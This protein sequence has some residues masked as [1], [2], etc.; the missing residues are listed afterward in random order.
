MPCNAIATASATVDDR[1]LIKHLD[2]DTMLAV[3]GEHLAEK[4]YEVT[5]TWVNTSGVG[6]TLN[7]FVTVRV[8]SNGRIDVQD[9]SRSDNRR[10]TELSQEVKAVIQEVAGVMFQNAVLA[11]VSQVCQVH[12]QQYAEDGTMILT[13]GLEGLLS[14][15]AVTL[16]GTIAVFTDEGSFEAGKGAIEQLFGTLQ[17]QFNF[18]EIG[19]VEQHR[20]VEESTHARIYH[21]THAHHH[22][23]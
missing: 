18:A 7:H 21:H 5:R 12:N 13:V 16:D 8:Y 17:R 9:R 2:K 10:A 3:I 23:G 11:Q 6:L 14:R 19:V 20:H 15:I 22:R 1:E 4:G